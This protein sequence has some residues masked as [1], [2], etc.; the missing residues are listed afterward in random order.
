LTLRET[1]R[2]PPIVMSDAL[3]A[4][5]LDDEAA[6]IRSHCLAHGRWKFTELEEVFPA[7]CQQVIDDSTRY[8]RMRRARASRG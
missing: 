7:E 4:N 5:T 2:G 1:E 3:S 8:S 6:I